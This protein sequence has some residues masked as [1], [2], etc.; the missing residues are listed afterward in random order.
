MQYSDS[1]NRKG[2]ILGKYNDQQTPLFFA[3][4]AS[5]LAGV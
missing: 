4:L 1:E 2:Y 3:S 5:R